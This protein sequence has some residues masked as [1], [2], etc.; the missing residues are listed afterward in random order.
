MRGTPLET[1]AP[2]Q[3]DRED[4]VPAVARRT[5]AAAMSDRELEI[6]RAEGEAATQETGLASE[7][8]RLGSASGELLGRLQAVKSAAAQAQLAGLRDPALA[9]LSQRVHGAAVPSL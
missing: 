9:E 1:T 2:E 3:L 7:L 6:R 4:D 5:Q 8:D